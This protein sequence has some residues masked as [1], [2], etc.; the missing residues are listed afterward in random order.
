MNKN[1]RLVLLYL[2]IVSFV[3]VGLTFL[4][5]YDLNSLSLKKF[6]LFYV[7]N[8]LPAIFFVSLFLLIIAQFLNKNHIKSIHQIVLFLLGTTL[9]VLLLTCYLSLKYNVKFPKEYLFNYPSQKVLEGI[10]LFVATF[11]QL[12][13]VALL[14]NLF[15][16]SGIIIY[17]KSLILVAFIFFIIFTAIFFYTTGAK[18]SADKIKPSGNAIGIVLGAAVWA[19][20]PSPLFKGRI[21]KAAELLKK[22]KIAKIQLTGSNAPGEISEAKAAYNYL[23]LLGVK[24]HLIKIEEKTTTTTEQIKYIKKKLTGHNVFNPVLIISDQFHLTRALEICKFFDVKAVGVASDYKLKWET[25]LYYR[26][27][28]S[29]ALMLFWLFAV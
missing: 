13:L 19:D 20:V 22:K 9:I 14:L 17:V 4:I 16:N 1:N 24:K 29:V 11:I 25:L 23:L 28:E 12:Y 2:L 15:F 10:L 6:N 8:L 3:G 26:L 27:R 5:K 7:G 18:Y 21:R